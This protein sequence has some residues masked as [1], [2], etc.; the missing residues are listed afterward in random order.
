MMAHLT[1][2]LWLNE[3]NSMKQFQILDWAGCVLFGVKDLDNH[4]NPRLILTSALFVSNRWFVLFVQQHIN[5]LCN[6]VST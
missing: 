6:K 4:I 2:K 5:S 1:L 3:M